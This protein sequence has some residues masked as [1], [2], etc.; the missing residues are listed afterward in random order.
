MNSQERQD[1]MS[2]FTSFFP[3]KVYDQP[4]GKKELVY[5]MGTGKFQNEI[6]D[7]EHYQAALEAICGPGKPQGVKCYETASLKLEDKNAVRVEIDGKLVGYLRP[8]TAS[9]FRQQLI[10]RGLPRGVGQCAAL[11]RGGSVASDGSK[12]PYKVLLDLPI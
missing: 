7:D 11:I 10:A 4:S 8:E 6:V 3:S 1:H 12:G 9:F 5:L 2:L